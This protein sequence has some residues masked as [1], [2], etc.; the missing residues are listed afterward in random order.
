MKKEE[1]IFME[2]INKNKGRITKAR[3]IILNEIYRRHDHFNADDIYIELK[4]RNFNISRAT[5]YRI[6]PV[7]LNAQLI[8]EVSTNTGKKLYEHILG[9][10]HHEHM[11]CEKC[12]ALIEF[13]DKIIE[14]N[15]NK[16]CSSINFVPKS[17]TI[18]ITGICK[19]CNIP[20]SH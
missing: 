13:K 18:L 1:N 3:I 19:K 9:H 12:G 17:H 11:K 15:I 5:I 6:F 20:V 7:L 8:R 16:L 4:N 14:K 2:Y 10:N